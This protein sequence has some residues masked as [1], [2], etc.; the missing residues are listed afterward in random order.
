M[1]Q[2]LSF[3]LLSSLLPFSWQV[4]A[5][6]E[7]ATE[8]QTLRQNV[9]SLHQEA[10]LFSRDLTLLDERMNFPDATRITIFNKLQL[11][12]PLSL[13]SIG[14]TLD[15]VAIIAHQYTPDDIQSLQHGAAQRL[16]TGN[17]SAGRHTLTAT[18]QALLPDNSHLSKTA[19]LTFTKTSIATIIQ[20]NLLDQ[21]KNREPGLSIQLQH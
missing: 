11:S 8:L 1:V 7:I 10:L 15:G 9:R 18:I 6:D 12:A 3:L 2:I 19:T 20:L 14:L 5:G 4:K 16:Y 13:R 17:I 21:G